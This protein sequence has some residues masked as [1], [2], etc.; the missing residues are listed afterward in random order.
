MLLDFRPFFLPELFVFVQNKT[1]RNNLRCYAC[2]IKAVLFI[3][4][5]FAVENIVDRKAALL[6]AQE[7]D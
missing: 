4:R 7:I 3:C 5:F 2:N 1:V 6:Q